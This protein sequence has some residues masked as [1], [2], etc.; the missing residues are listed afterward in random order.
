M[1]K[2]KDETNFEYYQRRK[3][4]WVEYRRK[5]RNKVNTYH[6]KYYV[7]HRNKLRENYKAFYK[8]NK[9]TILSKNRIKYATD[10]QYRHAILR[11]CRRDVERR[12]KA[13]KE[14]SLIRDC[15]LEICKELGLTKTLKRRVKYATR[16]LR[17]NAR[18]TQEHHSK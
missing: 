2:R 8:K 1:T 6:R 10:E 13:I 16:H 18:S 4:Y 15:A 7:K 17:S 14:R 12:R 3:T 9:N 11:R 5:N